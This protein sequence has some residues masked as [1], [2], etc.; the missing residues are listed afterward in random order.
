MRYQNWDVLI[1]PDQSKVPQQEF[2]TSC[3]IVQ[4]SEIFDPD[5]LISVLPTV[6]CFIP[7]L[8]AGNAFRVSIHSW[9][10]PEYT[11]HSLGLKKSKSISFEARVYIDV[12][13]DE[14]R[15]KLFDDNGP[16][17]IIIDREIGL[18]THQ[19]PKA[20]KF[21]AFH[22]ELVSQ[23]YWSPVDDLGRIKVVITECIAREDAGYQ[24]ER[25][26]NMLSFSFQHA[27]LHLLEISSIAWPNLAMWRRVTGAFSQ[28]L[29][30]NNRIN[31]GEGHESCSKS[32]QLFTSPTGSAY[33]G[34]VLSQ[35]VCNTKE[36]ANDYNEPDNIALSSWQ[37]SS[38]GHA[39]QDDTRTS[40]CT[41]CLPNLDSL[42]SESESKTSLE[43]Y[44]SMAPV[45]TSRI[46]RKRLNDELASPSEFTS[47]GEYI[48]TGND[49]IYSLSMPDLSLFDF[50]GL[51]DSEG[52]CDMEPSVCNDS[53]VFHDKD[54]CTFTSRSS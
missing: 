15:S 12:I 17:P 18:D 27:P 47:T 9:E 37:Q 52:L 4:D 14:P 46:K 25:I 16:W 44:E 13:I 54:L 43:Q 6:T 10:K 26:K 11:H 8:K 23:S 45:V 2:K 5:R 32:P 33:A 19:K 51:R 30:T 29:P 40:T 31:G 49:G 34:A 35:L 22:K 38:D 39:S 20:L 21:P 7:S 53:Q 3:Q 42:S 36:V 28:N 50:R 48:T 1:F 41:F 24:F